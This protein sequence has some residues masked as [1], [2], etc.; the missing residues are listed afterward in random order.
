MIELLLAHG[1]SGRSDLPIPAWLF[2][3]V[4]GAVLV[5]SFVLLGALWKTPKLEGSPR[6]P[7]PHDAVLRLYREAAEAA[8]C[9]RALLA[10]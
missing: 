7:L 3:W 5:I 6:R 1:L 9:S 8:P 4:A 2:A 10:T